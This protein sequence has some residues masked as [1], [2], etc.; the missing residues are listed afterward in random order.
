MLTCFTMGRN[1][2][3]LADLADDEARIDQ[4]LVDLDAAFN[5]TA[6]T[7]FDEGIVRAR[8]HCLGRRSDPV[9]LLHARRRCG[10][11]SRSGA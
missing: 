3:A 11:A 10:R 1:A 9:A 8:V 5:G 2:E 7:A 4:V 6:S